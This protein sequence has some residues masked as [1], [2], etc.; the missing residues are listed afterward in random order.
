M[1]YHRCTVG[2]RG[3]ASL[4]V[5]RRCNAGG[6]LLDRRSA[7]WCNWLSSKITVRLHIM[8]RT[9]FPRHICR[10]VC[11]SVCQTRELWQNE[12]NFCP[13]SYI[14]R[15]IIHRTVFWQEEWLVGA[16]LPHQILGVNWPHWSENADFQ[17]IF[18]RSASVATP[19]EK[20]FNLRWQ[21]DTRFPTTLRWTLYI[22][23]KPPSFKGSQ[24]R[25]V[26]ISH[27]SNAGPKPKG[28]KVW[29]FSVRCHS[30]W[31]IKTF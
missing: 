17:S 14:T 12:R 21:S 23:P 30:N 11:L 2:R 19:S 5:Q 18:A 24:K 7:S 29:D 13:Y 3:F 31:T 20:K 27:V 6:L 26:Q 1:D 16:T 9:V 25:S 8:Q 28:L 4:S 15:K 22:D 10:S